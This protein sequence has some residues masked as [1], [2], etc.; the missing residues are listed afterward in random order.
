[1]D[2]ICERIGIQD[3]VDRILELGKSHLEV[4]EVML[5]VG[6]TARKGFISK[7]LM[8]RSKHARSTCRTPSA[9]D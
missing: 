9:A 8:T 6:S 2:A 3:D 1:M 7:M 5:K 4:Q